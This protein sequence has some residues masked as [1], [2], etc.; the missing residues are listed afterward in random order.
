ML[1]FKESR[2][3]DDIVREITR[4]DDDDQFESIRCPLCGWRP[5]RSDLWCC[6]RSPDS[7]EPPF[8]FCGAEWN[9][10]ATH[11]RCIGCAH[12]WQ[13]TS[14]LQCHEWSRHDD[15]YERG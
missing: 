14:C 15:W 12:Q 3:T 9:T 13:W 4:L 8:Q 11:G 5:K 1:F 6:F 2:K 7:P 10:F